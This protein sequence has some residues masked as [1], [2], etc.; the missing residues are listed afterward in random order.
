MSHRECFHSGPETFPEAKEMMNHPCV[1]FELQFFDSD[2]GK[3][4]AKI[5]GSYIVGVTWVNPN[6]R[7]TRCRRS[8]MCGL[9]RGGFEL[10]CGEK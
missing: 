3:K 4:V 9:R 10:D 6:G 2:G 8:D 7:V 5:A 1:G